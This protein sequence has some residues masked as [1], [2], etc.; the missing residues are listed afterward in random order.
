VGR[1]FSEANLAYL[2]GL[3]DGD[4]A[5]MAWIE[6]HKEKRFKFRVRVVVKITQKDPKFLQDLQREICLG[7]VVGGNSAFELIV[8]N[9]RQVY[10]F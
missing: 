8:K 6:S 9:Q 1:T 2:A 10:S 4:G 3:I 5:I 7:R